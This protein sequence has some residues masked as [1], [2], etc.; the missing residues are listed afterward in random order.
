MFEEALL[1]EKVDMKVIEED[2]IWSIVF[3]EASLMWEKYKFSISWNKYSHTYLNN[4]S[5]NNMRFIIRGELGTKYFFRLA[6]ES[7]TA[8]EKSRRW[9][10]EKH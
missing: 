10:V 2:A 5:E 4:Q 8:I 3:E 1:D 7:P 6:Q 9:K